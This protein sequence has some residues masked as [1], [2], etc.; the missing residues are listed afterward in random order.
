MCFSSSP[1][2]SQQPTRHKLVSLIFDVIYLF[3]HLRIFNE[4]FCLLNGCERENLQW[5]LNNMTH[6]LQFCNICIKESGRNLYFRNH[7][8]V[9]NVKFH[10]LIMF[11]NFLMI[12]IYKIFLRKDEN[13]KNSCQQ[14]TSRNIFLLHAK[15]IHSQ[16]LTRL[17]FNIKMCKH[18]Y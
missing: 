15:E 5:L 16:Q 4:K 11:I 18:R 6:I 12:S 1:L 2:D 7:Y 8:Q 9:K 14:F 13:R 17:C 3:S 10:F